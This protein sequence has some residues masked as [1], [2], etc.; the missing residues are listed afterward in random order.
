M[1]AC[2]NRIK[3]IADDN[4]QVSW[5]RRHILLYVEKVHS[6]LAW[7]HEVKIDPVS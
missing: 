2:V 1:L 7:H 4:C 5:L 3:S 6:L